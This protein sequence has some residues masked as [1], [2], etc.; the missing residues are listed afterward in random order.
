MLAELVCGAQ[1]LSLKKSLLE[2]D[3]ELAARFCSHTAPHL[4]HCNS[5]R[6]DSVI[7]HRE[8]PACELV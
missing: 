1:I 6:L 2:I 7:A 3:L 4:P 8:T 5:A